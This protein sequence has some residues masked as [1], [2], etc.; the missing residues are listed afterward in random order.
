MIIIIIV[1]GGY[2]IISTLLWR[3]FYLKG[4][5]AGFN[6]CKEIDDEILGIKKETK[7]ENM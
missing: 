5:I 3:V 6:K 4:W 7:N 1:L 2:S